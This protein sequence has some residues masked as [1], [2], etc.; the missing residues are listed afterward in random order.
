MHKVSV[1]IC[2]DIVISCDIQRASARSAPFRSTWS[3]A[4][5]DS[6]L[7]NSA[8]HHV[9]AAVPRSQEWGTAPRSPTSLYTCAIAISPVV[10]SAV[11]DSA[12]W[13]SLA[14]DRNHHDL[15][16]DSNARIQVNQVGLQ[17]QLESSFVCRY[18]RGLEG[19]NSKCVSRRPGMSTPQ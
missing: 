10:K 3:P 17:L 1:V 4:G 11:V 5:T 8:V 13:M 15:C 6:P 16:R 2:C 19:H 7:P 9:Y 14:S 12:V 18:S